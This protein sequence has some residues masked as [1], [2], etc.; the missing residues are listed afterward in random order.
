MSKSLVIWKTLKCEC[1]WCGGG[2]GGGWGGGGG[3][4]AFIWQ[5]V[6]K[7]ISSEFETS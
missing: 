1:V 2:G 6:D 3:G 7:K 4:G 5:K